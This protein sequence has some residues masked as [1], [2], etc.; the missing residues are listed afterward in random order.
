MTA[1]T[2]P[3]LDVAGDDHRP[4]DFAYGHGRMPFF[5]KAIWGGFIAFGAWYVVKFLLSALATELG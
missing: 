4:H 3:D 2:S 5:M 1:P